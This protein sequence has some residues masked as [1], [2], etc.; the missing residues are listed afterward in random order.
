MN[1]E[2]VL[3]KDYNWF[4]SDIAFLG[5]KCRIFMIGNNL[6]EACLIERV[7]NN[8]EYLGFQAERMP[9]IKD[10]QPTWEGKYTKEFIDE[11]REKY[12]KLGKIDI[13][14]RE[15]MCESI[16]PES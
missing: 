7:I 5:K 13:W 15:R 9:I 8:K 10:G 1:S 14:Y 3:D 12:E 11:E 16:S 6:G 2:T 4:L